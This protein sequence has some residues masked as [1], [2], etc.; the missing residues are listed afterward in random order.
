MSP[1]TDTPAST[2][3]SIAD[4][5]FQVSDARGLGKEEKASGITTPPERA[6]PLELWAK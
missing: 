2:S 6:V 5:K 3:M 1:N 4:V